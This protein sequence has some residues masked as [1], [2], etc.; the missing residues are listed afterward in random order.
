MDYR[1]IASGKDAEGRDEGPATGTYCPSPLS[2]RDARP[3]LWVADRSQ[4]PALA[5]AVPVSTARLKSRPYRASSG[6]IKPLER[7]ILVAAMM[8]AELS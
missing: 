8:S 1:V 4:H 2:D 6:P 7:L 5:L 3:S